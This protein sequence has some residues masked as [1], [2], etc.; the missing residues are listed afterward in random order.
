MKGDVTILLLFRMCQW[1][2]ITLVIPYC[3]RYFPC[4]YGRTTTFA[5]ATKKKLLIS[6]QAKIRKRTLYV[7][8][9]TTEFKAILSIIYLFIVEYSMCLHAISAYFNVSRFS[10]WFASVYVWIGKKF[11][12]K[13]IV[14]FKAAV[15]SNK[16]NFQWGIQVVGMVLLSR[17]VWRIEIGRGTNLRCLC[18]EWLVKLL[19]TS[20]YSTH[21]DFALALDLASTS[22]REN[23]WNNW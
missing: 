2:T 18:S 16:T 22:T 11:L 12:T 15:H 19:V 21:V 6:N 17:I 13:C 20:V 3:H 1:H 10:M 8:I 14:Y 7:Q 5:N 9:N 23:K 4:T